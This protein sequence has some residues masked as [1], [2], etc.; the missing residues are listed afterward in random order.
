M[1]EPDE[2]LRLTAGVVVLGGLTIGFV[3]TEVGE[4][5]ILFIV[6]VVLALFVRATSSGVKDFEASLRMLGTAS[7]HGVEVL[8]TL[9]VAVNGVVW[10]L[11]VGFS[12]KVS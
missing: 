2:L 5:D 3:V 12:F 7:A 6:P 11:K 8:T 10:V 9:V 4:P 1:E